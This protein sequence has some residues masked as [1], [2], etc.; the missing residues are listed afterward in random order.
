MLVLSCMLCAVLAYVFGYSRGNKAPEADSP[1]FSTLSPDQEDEQKVDVP[2]R[3]WIPATDPNDQAPPQPVGPEATLKTFLA[4]ENWKA[5]SNFVIFADQLRP[6]MEKRAEEFDDGP[7]EVTGLSRLHINE[8]SHIF[9]VSTAKFPKGFP[10]AVAR[11]GAGWKVDWETFVEFNDDR[12]KRFA[13][14]EGGE[15]G[16]FHLMINLVNSEEADGLFS[17]YRLNPPMPDREQIG[18]VRNDSI[19]LARLRNIFREQAGL[20]E[21]EF[22]QL[23]EGAGPPLILALSYKT[24]SQGQSFLQIE[25]VIA[26]GWGPGE[27]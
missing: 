17:S 19:A 4:A 27:P 21:E 15:N 12:F 16:V 24:N 13:S 2:V 18:Y 14:G 6:R 8:D 11:D 7:I 3:D 10:V 1:V 23:L 20:P 9:N 5:R 26:V 25:D 22:A